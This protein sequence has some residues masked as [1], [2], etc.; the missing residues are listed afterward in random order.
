MLRM[1]IRE[2]ICVRRLIDCWRRW[3]IL[4]LFILMLFM[5]FFYVILVVYVFVNLVNFV[6][7]FM[8]ICK[9]I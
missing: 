4:F 9:E 8:E 1:F 6:L 5:S 7:I 2:F 3:V